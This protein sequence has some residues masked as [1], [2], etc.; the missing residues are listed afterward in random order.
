VDGSWSKEDLAREMGLDRREPERPARDPARLPRLCPKWRHVKRA[1]YGDGDDTFLGS[2]PSDA[3]DSDD[4][5]ELVP[6]GFTA[7]L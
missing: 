3:S 6:A 5:K 4:L 7:R 2:R 1:E